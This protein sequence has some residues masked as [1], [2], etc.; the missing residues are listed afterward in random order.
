MWVLLELQLPVHMLE[1]ILAQF[2]AHT[3][4][5]QWDQLVQ[6]FTSKLECFHS[7]HFTRGSMQM[8]TKREHEIQQPQLQ[9]VFSHSYSNPFPPAHVYAECTSKNMP[10]PGGGEVQTTSV[11]IPWIFFRI[12]DL[13]STP[14]IDSTCWN[15]MISSLTIQYANINMKL[16][17]PAMSQIRPCSL[18][19]ISCLNVKE[20]S[21]AVA[22][23]VIHGFIAF[24]WTCSLITPTGPKDIWNFGHVPLMSVFIVIF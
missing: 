17:L 11:I 24:S 1:M 5:E 7:R 22:S 21:K 16:M 19:I 18:L 6:C 14:I 20:D 10:W 9:H 13:A 8:S 4:L 3:D 23:V 15:A 2:I 12:V